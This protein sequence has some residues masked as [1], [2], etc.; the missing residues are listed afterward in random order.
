MLGATTN[1]SFGLQTF[2]IMLGTIGCHQGG[3]VTA[4]ARVQAFAAANIDALARD[5]ARGEG[6]TL[7]ALA[8]LLGVPRADRSAFGVLVQQ[9]FAELFPSDD[10]ASSALLDSLERVLAD[11]PRFAAIVRG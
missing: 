8:H 11:D 1:G 9:R 6:E 3:T 7:D 2:G 5:M 4:D 10:V